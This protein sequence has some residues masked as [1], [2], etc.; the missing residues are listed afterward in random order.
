VTTYL[1]QPRAARS[2]RDT[3]WIIDAMRSRGS[4]DHARSATKQLAGAA[5]YEFTQAF[6]NVPQSDEKRFL[7]QVISYMISRDA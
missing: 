7:E 1:G 5:L 6:G 2:V 4:L 3:R